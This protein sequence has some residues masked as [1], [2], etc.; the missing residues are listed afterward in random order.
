MKIACVSTSQVPSST[1]NSIQLMK[2]CHALQV[3]MSSATAGLPGAGHQVC[4]WTPGQTS[5][6]WD[7]LAAYYGLTQPFE[8]HWLQSWPLFRRYDFA[9][10]SLQQARAWAWT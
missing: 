6:S 3:A 9:M 7:M 2:V 5:P 1:A 10:R 8:L 4:L